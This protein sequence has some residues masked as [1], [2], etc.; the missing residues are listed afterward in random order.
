MKIANKPLFISVFLYLASTVIILVVTGAFD[1]KSK[2]N[3]LSYFSEQLRSELLIGNKRKIA[4][5]MYSNCRSLELVKLTYNFENENFN[6]SCDIS[7]KAF[8][9]IKKNI[10]YDSNKDNKITSFF[11]D[12]S[13]RASL[14]KVSLYLIG[15][16]FLNL[17]FYFQIKKVIAKKVLSSLEL[18]S[19]RIHIM[20]ARKLAHDIRSPLSSLNLIS[21]KISDVNAKDLQLQVINQ[22]NLIAD[23]L[24]NQTKI[25][26]IP[27]E[28]LISFL[29]TE[30][31]RKIAF[32]NRQILVEKNM[33]KKDLKAFIPA[34]FQSHLIN[35]L[36]NAIEAT[37]AEGI[38]KIIFQSIDKTV[39]IRIKD[40]GAGIPN[41]VLIQL[42]KKE[43][44]YDS[45]GSKS[46]SG[47]GIAI[48]NLFNDIKKLNGKI[49]IKSKTTEGTE[50][51][52]S[53]PTNFESDRNSSIS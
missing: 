23:S 50:I 13:F 21:S 52:V 19:N 26:M 41:H 38:I 37:S 31:P 6:L 32:F 12:L 53:V 29:E 36:Q 28:E 48:I 35:L 9:T 39:E 20:L 42:G 10:F 1:Y 22:I 18:E 2:Q 14:Q 3:S 34:N 25:K 17:L 43:I 24:L 7:T 47:N 8:Y 44:S 45:V 16:F 5:L 27:F 30:I 33:A 40:N 4:E 15:L 46:F 49:E 51:I 11:F